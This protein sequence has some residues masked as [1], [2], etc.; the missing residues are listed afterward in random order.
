MSNMPS[1]TNET[2]HAVKQTTDTNIH[3]NYEP[4]IPRVIILN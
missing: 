3:A 4:N 1:S 2:K